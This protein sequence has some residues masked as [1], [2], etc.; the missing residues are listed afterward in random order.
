METNTAYE[1]PTDY[2]GA[3]KT[4]DVSQARTQGGSGVQTN[5]PQK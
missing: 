1:F 2:V 3:V 4:D 5:R